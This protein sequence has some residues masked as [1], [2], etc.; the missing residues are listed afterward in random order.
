M[1]GMAKPIP[2]RYRLEY[3]G[4]RTVQIFVTA[5]PIRWV[6]AALRALVALT[7]R[8]V[9]PLRKETVSR[10]REVFG[11][12]TSE[13]RCR[14]IASA[15][16][17]NLLMNFVELFHAPRM[18]ADYL[19]AHLEGTDAAKVR[20][21]A[22]IDK[23]G[24]AVIALPH[25]GNWDLAGVACS[26]FG[27]P[28]MA[29]ARAQNNPYVEA[30]MQRNRL[31]NF[32]A[33]DRRHTSAFVRIVHHLKGGGAFAILPDVRH[34][35]PA[36]PVTVF[37]KPDVQLGKG[38]SKFARMANVPIVPFFMERLDADHHRLHL[39]EPIFPDLEA[40]ADADAVR[41]TQ[42]VWDLFEAKIREQPEQ[43]FW[44]NRRW[45]LTPLYTQTRHKHG[46]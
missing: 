31:D 32:E 7:F 28:L 41:I 35:K 42:Q 3:L 9:W 25:M 33:L 6:G 12:E 1:I 17:W 23:Y 19:R 44:F 34:N 21:Q 14:Q 39:G 46:S 2:F 20:L 38:V 10:I 30:W 45:I 40:D 43:W 24:G 36:V 26:R 29:L 13:S 15:S 18:D 22:L 4:L 37:G 11:P 8:L 27:I 16:V 5:L